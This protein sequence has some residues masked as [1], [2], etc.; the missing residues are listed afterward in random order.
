MSYPAL[1]GQ[2]LTWLRGLQKKIAITGQVKVSTRAKVAQQVIA[3]CIEQDII[4]SNSLNIP[5]VVFNN[6]L[7]DDIAK[8]QQQLEQ[9]DFRQFLSDKTR[10]ESANLSNQEIKTVGKK[11]R[12]L[13][14]LVRLTALHRLSNV[15]IQIADIDWQQLNLSDFSTLIVVEN[16]D[17]F[18]Q[19][20]QFEI[21]LNLSHC[22][23]IYR[24]DTLYSKGAKALQAAWLAT[25]KTMIYFGDFDA[26]GVSIALHEHY[27]TILLP[28]FNLI[29]QHAASAMLPDTQ[30]PFIAKIQQYK[31][32][33]AFQPYLQL[34]CQQLKSLRQQRMQNLPLVAIFLRG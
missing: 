20:E 3:W 13:R 34:L 1:K 18:Y 31:V 5:E 11:P 15:P 23:V 24:G 29:K 8:V 10:L 26:K 4:S 7:L 14:V 32:S 9:V 2:A 22:L 19:L 12:E 17:C 30:L 27:S 25:N 21:A 16:L 28:S 6:R 33:S